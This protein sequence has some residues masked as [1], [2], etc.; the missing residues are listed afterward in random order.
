MS[1]GQR[2][3]VK[4]VW[5][6]LK[7]LREE[8]DQKIS[9]ES[10]RRSSN[11]LRTL[12]VQDQFS[13]AWRIIGLENQPKVKAQDLDLYLEDS[14]IKMISLAQA[15]GAFYHG[16]KIGPIAFRKEALSPEQIKKLVQKSP[17][18]LEREFYLKEYLDSTCMVIKGVKISR[19]ALIKYIANKLGGTHIDF[20]RNP[21]IEEDKKFIAL[22]AIPD[23][24]EV[25]EKKVVYL[26]LLGIGQCIARSSDAERFISMSTNGAFLGRT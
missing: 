16:M 21:S 18:A 17:D 23:R 12:L 6:D 7:Y 26:E 1:K 13:K 9:D 3:L 10:L 20:H 24:L 25:G 2:Y 8:W 4:V 19:R 5:D 14:D 22:D 11:V 15:G